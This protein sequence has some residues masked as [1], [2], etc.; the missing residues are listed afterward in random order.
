[1]A[2]QHL[3]ILAGRDAVS[4][5]DDTRY[6]QG[7]ILDVLPEDF[8]LD[9]ITR[10]EHLAVIV[11]NLTDEEAIMLR[12][13]YYD[14]GADYIEPNDISPPP[15][16]IGKR[17]Y[18]VPF[19]EIIRYIPTFEPARVEDPTDDYQPLYDNNIIPNAKQ[20]MKV[21]DKWTESLKGTAPKDWEP[22]ISDGT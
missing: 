6:K 15:A 19:S 7:D 12:N 13:L 22:V 2:N 10:K 5:P 16:I 21:W 14:D 17:K 20:A 3:I 1:M 11:K 4:N 18:S 8:P 9:P